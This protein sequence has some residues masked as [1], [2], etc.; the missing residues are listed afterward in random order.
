LAEIRRLNSLIAGSW[1]S[2]SEL[3]GFS[4]FTVSH[5]GPTFSILGKLLLVN[6]KSVVS[7]DV[8]Q[9]TCSP[10]EARTTPA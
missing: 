4:G 10:F 1:A 3:G 7:E 9:G 2:S 5:N 6:E 8:S